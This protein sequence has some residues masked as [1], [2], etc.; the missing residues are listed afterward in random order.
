M[1]MAKEAEA[2]INPRILTNL[3]QVEEEDD[4]RKVP[5]LAAKEKKVA[6]EAVTLRA[7]YKGEGQRNKI[8]RF[9]QFI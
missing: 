7:Q 9:F 3:L 8:D 1:G 4:L 6:E 5:P 2:S